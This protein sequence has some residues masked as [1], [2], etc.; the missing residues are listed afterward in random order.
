MK[1]SRYLC[2]KIPN[3]EWVGALIYT[4]TGNWEDK[5][6]EV[7]VLDIYPLYEANGMHFEDNFDFDYNY[8][9]DKG[10]DIGEIR[11]GLIHSHCA[12]A[13]FFSGSDISELQSTS[14]LHSFYLS[15][16][17]NNRNEWT[18]KICIHNE[19]TI[20]EIGTVKRYNVHGEVVTETVNET[21]TKVD[22]TTF[23]CKIFYETEEFE[24]TLFT[25]RVSTIIKEKKQRNVSKPFNYN[26]RY[27]GYGGYTGYSNYGYNNQYKKDNRE[28]L[29][30][31]IDSFFTD[32]NIDL[33]MLAK[34]GNYDDGEF[35]PELLIAYIRKYFTNFDY[36]CEYNIIKDAISI[37]SAYTGQFVNDLVKDYKYYLN[38]NS[39]KSWK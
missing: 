15:L 25:N 22:Y 8:A 1:Q 13:V 19:K 18:G 35:A 17:T 7:K 14:K 6:L 4:F 2:D 37:V 26:D 31:A 28:S 9:I 30:D 23:D 5:T 39:K 27:D 20:Q 33:E 29:K 38:N 36:K 16:I 3:D 32:E 11:I 12:S 21:V 10:Y 34:L 24:D